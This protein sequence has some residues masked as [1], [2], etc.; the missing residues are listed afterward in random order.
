MQNLM[1]EKDVLFD[2]EIVKVL[3]CLPTGQ[4]NELVTKTNITFHE[5]IPN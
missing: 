3:Y 1:H 4:P 5:G 2:R